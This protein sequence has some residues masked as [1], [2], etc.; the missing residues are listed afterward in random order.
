MTFSKYLLIHQLKNKYVQVIPKITV[1]GKNLNELSAGQ[2]GTF[3][4]CL[5]L[6]TQLF[7]GPIIFDQPEDDLDND[8]ITNQLID[9]FKDIKKYRQVIIVSHNANLVVNADSEQVIIANNNQEN[10]SYSSGSLKM[11]R[12]ILRSAE[13]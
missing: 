5:K 9:L 3:Y 8:F 6:A 2:K 4:L 1:E 11:Y 7:S 12:L 10:L 13:F